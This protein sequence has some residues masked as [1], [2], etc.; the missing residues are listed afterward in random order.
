MA[1]DFILRRDKSARGLLYMSSAC[2][3]H[4][5]PGLGPDAK[6]L[7]E[8]EHHDDCFVD[9][10]HGICGGFHR[11]VDRSFGDGN[12]NGSREVTGNQVCLILHQPAVSDTR[13]KLLDCRPDSLALPE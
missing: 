8:E 6:S 13:Y 1:Y 7:R 12:G 11:A 3:T 10:W 4:S 9:Q 2:T 5:S